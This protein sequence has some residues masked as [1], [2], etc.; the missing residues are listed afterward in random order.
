MIEI[1]E[2]KFYAIDDLFQGWLGHSSNVLRPRNLQGPLLQRVLLEDSVSRHRALHQPEGHT[3]Q[4]EC[5][6]DDRDSNSFLP[7]K[8]DLGNCCL[9]WRKTHLHHLS[10]ANS[11]SSCW[12][13]KKL[14]ACQNG[15]DA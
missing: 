9:K 12:T 11:T 2:V 7:K 13:K 1:I 15:N 8:M 6:F 14:P 3:N 4:G 5:L 10:K